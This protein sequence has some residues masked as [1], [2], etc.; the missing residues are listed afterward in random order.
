MHSTRQEK[1]KGNILSGCFCNSA[2]VGWSGFI[3]VLVYKKNWVQARNGQYYY[4]IFI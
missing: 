1:K 2:L 4:A 3:D